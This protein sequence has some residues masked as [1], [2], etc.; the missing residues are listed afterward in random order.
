MIYSTV[1]VVVVMV[2]SNVN[3]GGIKKRVASFVLSEKLSLS[4]LAI[5]S[6][7]RSF[8]FVDRFKTEKGEGQ[9]Q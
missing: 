4:C 1:V 3:D 7:D 6:Q 9:S 8:I 5:I 2:A